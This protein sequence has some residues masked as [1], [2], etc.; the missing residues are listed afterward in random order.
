[1]F[2]EVGVDSSHLRR[3]WKDD[4]QSHSI[5]KTRQFFDEV[6]YEVVCVLLINKNK[7]IITLERKHPSIAFLD[8][9]YGLSQ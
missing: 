6:F 8:A 9:Y 2:C 5:N 4:L 3:Y 7:T 1:M